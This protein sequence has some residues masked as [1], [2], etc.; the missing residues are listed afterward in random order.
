MY[1]GTHVPL[2]VLNILR[3]FI[4]I[5]P[6]CTYHKLHR[7][8]PN[9]IVLSWFLSHFESSHTPTGN[10][11][12]LTR[13]WSP[14]LLLCCCCWVTISSST[15]ALQPIHI[16]IWNKMRIHIQNYL[17][18]L[19]SI[20]FLLQY[21]YR[22][23]QATSYTIIISYPC[24]HSWGSAESRY[25]TTDYYYHCC[26]VLLTHGW[27][28]AHS[29]PPR[30]IVSPLALMSRFFPFAPEAPPAQGNTHTNTW[31]QTYIYRVTDTHTHTRTHHSFHK[32]DTLF[33]LSVLIRW[34]VDGTWPPSI[35]HLLLDIDPTLLCPPSDRSTSI[36]P[37]IWINRNLV[38]VL[39]ITNTTI[40]S[41]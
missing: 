9:V 32:A 5:A 37:G 10:E 28:A 8:T 18:N 1:V 30:S 24:L 3:L 7:Y 16:L 20:K 17:W 39:V 11:P 26:Y 36:L 15:R 31:W 13:R 25:M 19:I 23:L 12:L 33:A 4:Y 34:E 6:H 41:F 2:W 14:I 29:F 40:P 35:H 21:R 27:T 38:I 22:P